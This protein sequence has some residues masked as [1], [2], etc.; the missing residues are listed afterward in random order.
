M[1]KRLILVIVTVLMT[2]GMQAQLSTNPDKFLGNITTEWQIDYGNEPFY[3]LWNQITPENESKWDQIEGAARNSFNWTNCDRI[4][5]YAK[6]HGFPFK[7][8]T[9]TWGAQYP[10]WMNNL[11][12]EDQLKAYTEWMN[13]VRRK[14]ADLQM[15]DVVN[16]A[17]P[18]HAPAPYKDALGG[19]G[20]T[21]YDWIIEAFEMAYKRWP[22]AILIYND[23][24][25]FQGNTDQFIELVTKLRDAGAPIDAYGCQSHELPYCS[26]TTLKNA[27]NK[28]QNALKMPMYITEYDIG[29]SDDAAQLNDY[30]AHIPLFW[31]ADYCAGVTLWGY[32]YGKT[33]TNDGAGYSGL[34]K[35]SQDGSGNTVCTDRPA[36]SWLRGYMQSNKAIQ[37]KSPF[38]GMQ[39]EASVYVRPA[40]LRVAPGESTSIEVRAKM[41]TKTIDH[42]DF[43][44]NNQLYQTMTESPYIVEYTPATK[45]K[46][47]LKA[48]VTT[49]DGA[50]YERLS[51]ISALEELT[52]RIYTSM[53]QLTDGQ[54]FVI[55]DFEKGKAFYG[56]GEQNLGFDD[57]TTAFTNTSVGYYFRLE[58]LKNSS[59]T[60]VR[61]YYLLR[62][63]KLDGTEYSIWGRPGYLN[64]QRANQSCCF[65]LGLNNQ[66]GEDFKNGAVWDVKYVEGQ[67]FTLRNIGTG[68]Y[69][70][71]AA[72]AKYD[73]PA[74]FNFCTVPAI[75]AVDEVKREIVLPMDNAIY[76]MQGVKVGTPATWET[77]AP[78]LYIMNGK[79]IIKK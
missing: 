47:S 18:G 40:S 58:S 44:V 32:I 36:M 19:D 12:K 76:N 30:K 59:D 7:F 35:V 39:K 28:I 1:S 17:I 56:A 68:K 45:G 26:A 42:V 60:S 54:P 6:D 2:V 61:N 62:L 4:H 34:I 71:D 51:S 38:P 50:T 20:V 31:E 67:G 48:V 14:Y 37:A 46:Y 66:N 41:R 55:A 69:L 5:K 52:S 29:N 63:L 78:G 77:L 11:S 23:Y 27:M 9:L 79:K 43:Y 33:W 15:I 74:Y 73:T 53:D 8:H 25:T 10:Q 75:T 13:A 72:P 22:N 64:S 3:T 24:N 65:I 57:Y 16:E 70:Q 21:G 49:T